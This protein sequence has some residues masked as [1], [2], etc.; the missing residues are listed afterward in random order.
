[1]SVVNV[2]LQVI[3][4]VTE[5]RIYPVVDKVIEYIQNSGVKYEVGP[6]ETTMEGE[7]SVLLEIVSKAQEICVAS[8]ASRV[9]SVVKIDYK[10]EGVT[11]NEKVYKYRK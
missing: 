11:M 6:M 9:L 7:L 8:G 4:V 5:D 3:P 10:A 2:S 1:M